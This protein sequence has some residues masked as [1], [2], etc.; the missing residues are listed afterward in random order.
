MSVDNADGGND[1]STTHVNSNWRDG[2]PEFAREWDEVKNS[3]TAD[4]F[5][6]QVEGQRKL[7]GQSVRI[8]GADAGADQMA[9]FYQKIQS[10]V[11]GLMRTPDLDNAELMKE[12]MARLGTP[13]DAT[14][15]GD[16][17]NM[18]TARLSELRDLAHG[19]GLTKGQFKKLAAQM[20]GTDKA[21]VELGQ[22]AQKEQKDMLSREW[23]AALDVRSKQAVELAR[24]TGAPKK[25]LEAAEA[26][27]IDADTMVWL[28][29]M[30][31]QMGIEA[32]T[33]SNQGSGVMAPAEATEQISDMMNNKGH[34]YWDNSHPGH[35]KAV[36]KMIDLQRARMA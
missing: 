9:E 18:E 33:I 13:E 29:G 5:Y 28:H 21:T 11:P 20:Q 31:K 25:L 8:P 17:E 24:Q 3:D 23:G 4:K 2:V 12:T 32:P 10:K 16:V 19:A 15:Y 6:Q 14:G 26:G 30:S 36:D 35:K 22:V 7:L 1:T 34:P 27:T